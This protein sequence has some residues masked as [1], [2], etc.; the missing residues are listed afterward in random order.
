MDFV[1]FNHVTNADVEES[2]CDTYDGELFTTLELGIDTRLLPRRPNGTPQGSI[3][4][5]L[6]H[7]DERDDAGI[8]HGWG[9]GVS[10]VQTFGR[11]TAFLRYGCA[12][13]I[14]GQNTDRIGIGYTWTEAADSSLG[15]QGE[16]DG[17]YRVQ[18]TPEIEIGPTFQFIFDPV[19]NPDGDT[20]SVWSIR[21]RIA[22]WTQ[23]RAGA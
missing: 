19:C 15:S 2:G 20:I 12:D 23:G 11:L 3:H 9:I 16:I 18:L 14:F 5:L 6:W 7:Q 17:F 21:T 1:D 13:G 22:F 4:T 10:A 8:D